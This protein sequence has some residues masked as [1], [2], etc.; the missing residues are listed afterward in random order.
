MLCLDPKQRITAEEALKHPYFQ[1]HPP[2]QHPSMMP[3]YPSQAEGGP[4]VELRHK[5]MYLTHSSNS[6][7]RK[8]EDKLNRQPVEEAGGLLNDSL[9]SSDT[10][11]KLKFG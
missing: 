5:T 4:Y 6:R 2:P 8:N 1:E 9:Y 3:T 7:N 10:G 11:F